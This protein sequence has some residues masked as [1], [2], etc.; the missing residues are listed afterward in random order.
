MSRQARF[1][2]AH[3]VEDA[4]ISLSKN[5]KDNDNHKAYPKAYE[6][7]RNKFIKKFIKSFQKALQGPV[8]VEDICRTPIGPT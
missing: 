8:P 5:R 1:Q 4:R 2:K 3:Q 6:M 7:P